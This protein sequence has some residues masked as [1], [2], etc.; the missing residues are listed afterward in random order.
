MMIE[1]VGLVIPE[2][3]ALLLKTGELVRTNG[4]LRNAE[5]MEIF[6]HLEIVDLDA[7]NCWQE[8]GKAISRVVKENKVGVSIAIG[9]V[10]AGGT[11]IGIH[12]FHKRKK[13][14]EL[15]AKCNAWINKAINNYIQSAAEGELNVDSVK[16]CE[17]ALLSLPHITDKVFVSMTKEQII[18]FTKNLREYT[19]RLA[20]VNSYEI[21]DKENLSYDGNVIICFLNNLRVQREILEMAA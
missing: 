10:I 7:E 5:N 21:E 17:E 16:L 18:E 4:V 8:L 13:A 11:A 12:L 20:E 2:K 3:E 19:E 14:K 9:V 1:K 15:E 6:K